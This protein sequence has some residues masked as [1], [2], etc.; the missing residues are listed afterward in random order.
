MYRKRATKV[1]A[2]LGPASS[3]EATIEALHRE[4]V[5][6]F[7]LN[8]SHGTH[9]DHAARLDAIRRVEERSGSPIGV[10]LDLQGPKLRV[11]TFRDG[12]ANVA[13]GDTFFFDLD[14][15]EGS[16]RRVCLPHPEIFAAAGVGDVLLVNDGLLR[17]KVVDAT[18]TR[19]KTEVIVGG[20][21]SDR[22][23]VNFPSARLPLPALSEKDR[24]DLEYGL[25]CG[26][27]WIALSFV[28]RPEDLHEARMLIKGRAKLLAKIE[29]PAAI[30][31][32]DEII[33]AADAIMLARGDLGVEL[34][35]EDVPAIQK[36]V[37]KLCRIAGKPVVVATQM[38]ESMVSS[39]SPTRAE[40]S[41]VAT[42]VYDGVDAV[43]LSAES[44]S[45][46][47]PIEAVSMMNRIIERT[48]SDPSYRQLMRAMDQPESATTT[49]AI[50]AAIDTITGMLPVS[51]T[52]TYTTSGMTAL[53]VVR[54]RPVSR[55]VSLTPDQSVARQLCLSWGTSS[56]KT[57]DAVD[58]EDMVVKARAAAI[59]AGFGHPEKPILIAAG[60]PFGTPGS[61]NLLRI[62]W[63]S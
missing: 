45:G 55:I 4:G 43:M 25:K 53:R 40:A 9:E 42:A 29:K 54:R 60:I 34:P 52:V 13:S 8:F 59:R 7:R 5:D 47:Y 28:Q 11:A 46:K 6:V 12:F 15:Q 20:R 61:S 10:L 37:V 36:R 35:P 51:A 39:A 23:G 44:A 48:E 2:T 30:E 63:P 1:I 49:D 62:V 16:D 3:D 38:L 33:E 14:P 57:D 22:K 50:G 18:L 24:R 31:C 56:L 19:L 26:V 21:I 41:D 32:I 17:F 58:V 27:D